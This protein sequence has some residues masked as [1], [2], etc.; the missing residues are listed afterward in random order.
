MVDLRHAM[1]E[2]GRKSKA[3]V[4][5]HDG[6]MKS[7]D[8][9]F[10]ALNMQDK[11]TVAASTEGLNKMEMMFFREIG[12]KLIQESERQQEA[13]RAGKTT[14]ISRNVMITSQYA[15]LVKAIIKDTVAAWQNKEG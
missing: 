7:T 15:M 9:V 2:M 12:G 5:F 6:I 10:N 1:S 3:L 14:A 8:A 13:L 4:D 11:D